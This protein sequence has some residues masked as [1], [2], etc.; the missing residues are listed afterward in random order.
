MRIRLVEHCFNQTLC[1]VKVP[2]EPFRFPIGC[3]EL[4]VTIFCPRSEKD[5]RKNG[6]KFVLTKQRFSVRGEQ[7]C[8]GPVGCLWLTLGVFQ[9]S[10]FWGRS[11]LPPRPSMPIGPIWPFSPSPAAH[12]VP[13]ATS[14]SLPWP[15]QT[16]R[17]PIRYPRSQRF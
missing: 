10:H 9:C 6:R 3:F 2:I 11:R 1:F 12:R 16:T 8:F 15:T 17:R 4:Q 7:G 14:P 13:P 5:G